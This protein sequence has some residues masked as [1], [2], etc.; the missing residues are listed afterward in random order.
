[1][2][3]TIKDGWFV[4]FPDGFEF[5]YEPDKHRNT[6]IL[7]ELI[8]I[9]YAVTDSLEATSAVLR[10]NDYVSAH[11]SI[12]GFQDGKR[13]RF[14]VIQHVPFDRRAGHAGRDALYNGRDD[15]NGFAIGI[16]IANPGPLLK[17]PDGQLETTY[18]RIWHERPVYE[19]PHQKNRAPSNWT[20]WAQ[21]TAE[22]YAIL[23]T[24]CHVLVE[25]YPTITDIVGHDDIR[26]TKFDPGPAFDLAWLRG[27]VFSS[28]DT[29][30]APP[31]QG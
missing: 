24:I 29:E 23:A 28:G 10:A 7:P 9:H 11:L 3:W 16:E 17:R 2:V 31:P 18:G 14:G 4:S 15:V 8:V 22:E 26:T 6:P 21:Y 13:S 5:R 12:D 30:P 20:H 27:F 19:G 1:M 25:T